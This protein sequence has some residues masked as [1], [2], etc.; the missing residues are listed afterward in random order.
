MHAL[1]TAFC[2]GSPVTH[3]RR[4][5]HGGIAVTC[6]TGRHLFVV[7]VHV[8]DHAPLPRVDRLQDRCQGRALRLAN[9]AGARAGFGFLCCCCLQPPHKSMDN[10]GANGSAQQKVPTSEG[11]LQDSERQQQDVQ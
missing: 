4:S 5:M 9:R 7:G 11:Q 6:S 3:L 1:C 10:T 2:G 8:C